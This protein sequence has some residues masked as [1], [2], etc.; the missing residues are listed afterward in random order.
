MGSALPV[1]DSIVIA[2]RDMAR[3]L[4]YLRRAT[5]FHHHGL[6]LELR[7]FQY[8]VLLDWRELRSS[9]EQP[10]DALCDGLHGE[11]VHS[12]D[13]AL[14]KLRLRPLHEAL[15]QAISVGNVH[16]FTEIAAE[17]A[18]KHLSR[19]MKKPVAVAK[20][21]T[22][23]GISS[24]EKTSK[25]QAS[26]IVASNLSRRVIDPRLQMFAEKSYLCF[27]RALENLP[28]ED[29]DRIESHTASQ[30]GGV[31]TDVAK[32]TADEDRRAPANAK[33]HYRKTCEAL[34]AAALHLPRLEQAFSTAWPA[35]V[36]YMLPGN[37][38]G[39]SSEQA[40]A[41]VLAWIVLRSVPT[42]DNWSALYDKL[43]LRSALAEIFSSMGMEGED[44]WQAAARVRVL[45]VH[46]DVS[47]ELLT[48]PLMHSEVFWADPDVRWL[49]G[50]N[51]SSGK[52]YFNKEQF[53]EMLS[54]VQLP[55]LIEIAQQNADPSQALSQ[56]EA[57]IS[58]ACHAAGTAGYNLDTYLGLLSS[59]GVE[60][61]TASNAEV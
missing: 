29:R 17:L 30:S 43:H 21:Q 33:D 23:D 55:E 54:W 16:L 50:V 7:G 24:S 42:Q 10:W 40:W 11:G 18:A 35:A 2:Y 46:A 49:T 37:E 22:A 57:A 31:K 36:R 19:T 39:T 47:S 12:V 61:P 9:A 1:E 14:T 44:T 13:E 52:T 41:P 58:K 27:E 51:I 6:S 28:A 48:E 45:L 25:G 4:E 32:D 59:D 56:A 15:H 38:P 26:E 60:K 53:E 3:G 34:T 20:K 5:D 8:V